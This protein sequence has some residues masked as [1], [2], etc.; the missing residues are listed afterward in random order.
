MGR[1]TLLD[2]GADPEVTDDNGLTPLHLAAYLGH[3]DI[4]TTLVSAGADIHARDR[5]GR[6]PLIHA[7]LDGHESIVVYPTRC[8]TSWL[9]NSSLIGRRKS[10]GSGRGVHQR[11]P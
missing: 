2:Q 5:L 6:T 8:A 3:R 10:C 11:R 7:A 9:K 4:V 1:R